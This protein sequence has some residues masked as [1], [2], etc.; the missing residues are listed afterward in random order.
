MVRLLSTFDD[1]SIHLTASVAMCRA[2]TDSKEVHTLRTSTRKLEALFKV[3]TVEHRGAAK[4]LKAIRKLLK[5]LDEIRKAAGIVRDFDVQRKIVEAVSGELSNNHRED[6]KGEIS[7]D[8]ETLQEHFRKNRKLQ[9][10]KL[11]DLLSSIEVPLQ[12]ELKDCRERI[13][14]LQPKNTTP[15]Q[16]AKRWIMKNRPRGI[17]KFPD[18][19]HDFRKNTKGARYIAE[20]QPASES[21][22]SLAEDLH[23]MHDAI[24]AWHDYDLLADEARELIGKKSELTKAILKKRDM[25]WKQALRSVSSLRKQHAALFSSSQQFR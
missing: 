3:A 20:L 14:D 15:H 5:S 1:L 6:D 4:A 23:S 21:S 19:L 8:A 11:R 24:G 2:R 7:A 10:K 9:A 13:A 17:S 16:C 22:L 25:S 12:S 18:R